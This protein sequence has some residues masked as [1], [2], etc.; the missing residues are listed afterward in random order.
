MISVR[1]GSSKEHG[2][3]N[4]CAQYVRAKDGPGTEEHVVAVVRMSSH[5]NNGQEIRL[6]TSCAADLKSQLGRLP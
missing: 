2:S 1:W 5:R 3:C 4:G 6:C